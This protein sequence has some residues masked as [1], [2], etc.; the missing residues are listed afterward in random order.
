MKLCYKLSDLKILTGFFFRKSLIFPPRCLPPSIHIGIFFL[1]YFFLRHNIFFLPRSI[2]NFHFAMNYVGIELRIFSSVRAYFRL[3][4]A[5]AQHHWCRNFLFLLES[6]G[7]FGENNK[8]TS[9]LFN[10]AMLLAT[11]C[12]HWQRGSVVLSQLIREEEKKWKGSRL[13]NDSCYFKH[14]RF[15]AVIKVRSCLVGIFSSSL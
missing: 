3:P 10:F 11:S 13:V 8:F 5:L 9:A 6:L 14:L 7:I 15:S 2:V 1:Q 12:R 4:T